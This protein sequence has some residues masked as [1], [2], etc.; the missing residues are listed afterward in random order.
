MS[1]F[2]KNGFQ[3]CQKF[4]ALFESQASSKQLVSRRR[5]AGRDLFSFYIRSTSNL[6]NLMPGAAIAVLDGHLLSMKNHL[7]QQLPRTG[8]KTKHT[9]D[10]LPTYK[11]S[12][13]L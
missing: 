11:P 6:R 10:S 2:P 9:N 7:S 4:P 3:K 12:K 5:L 13:N 1:D 8:A